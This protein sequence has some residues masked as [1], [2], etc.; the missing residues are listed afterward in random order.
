MYKSLLNES[1]V[2]M[3]MRRM[4]TQQAANGFSIP[5]SQTSNE[6]HW[7]TTSNFSFVLGSKDHHVM[8]LSITRQCYM[9]TIETLQVAVVYA[10]WSESAILKP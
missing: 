8:T 9:V 3:K 5:H 7:I 1:P 6:F 10:K 4:Y 2:A